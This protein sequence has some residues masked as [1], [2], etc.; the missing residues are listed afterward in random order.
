[1]NLNKQFDEWKGTM[2]Y[3]LVLNQADIRDLEKKL[4]TEQRYTLDQ[5]PHMPL[6]KQMLTLSAIAKLI[7]D[8]QRPLEERPSLPV[9]GLPPMSPAEFQALEDRHW[10]QLS[11]S[12]ASSERTKS[13]SLC[14]F[15][16]TWGDR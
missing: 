1:V 12:S 16:K 10:P 15:P 3:T 7:S 8:A 14:E 11:D 2:N 13:E 4:T 5:W 9:S 6:W